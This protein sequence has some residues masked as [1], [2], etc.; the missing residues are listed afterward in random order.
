MNG[1]KHDTGKARWDLL[2]W[3]E[4][5]G[6]AQVL[7]LG[8]DKYAP[9]NWQGLSTDRLFAAAMR[10]ITAHIGGEPRDQET[11]EMHLHHAVCEL[12][13]ISWISQNK[14]ELDTYKPTTPPQ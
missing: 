10:H 8:A 4:L 6:I 1:I 7:T 5:D 14:P 12:L 3:S 2:P 13:F 11:Q 9:N